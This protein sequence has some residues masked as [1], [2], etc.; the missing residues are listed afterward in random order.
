MLVKYATTELHP[1][2]LYIVNLWYL[3][4]Y[5][6]GRTFSCVE[7]LHSRSVPGYYGEKKLVKSKHFT[8]LPYI[9]NGIYI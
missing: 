3:V 8:F 6:Q 7:L 5:F 1:L 4:S 2:P 9:P